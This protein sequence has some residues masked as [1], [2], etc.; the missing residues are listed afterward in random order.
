MCNRLSGFQQAAIR[1]LAGSIIDHG[2]LIED[3]SPTVNIPVKS[4]VPVVVNVAAKPGRLMQWGTAV[5][6]KLVFNARSETITAKPL[7][8]DAAAHRRCLM[9]ADGFFEFETLGRRKLGHYFSLPGGAAFAIAGIWLPATSDQ[10]DRCV[11]VTNAP[12]EL[13]APFHDRMPTILTVPDAKEWLG[14]GPLP[15]DAI[16][17]LCQMY[18]ADQMCHWPSPAAMNSASYQDPAALRPAVREP[19]LFG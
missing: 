15:P 4:Q 16:S 13:I 19:D 7:W 6:P 11:M 17:R 10:P 12:N 9:L 3:W 8:R 2:E 5:P 1:A 18:P 14:A